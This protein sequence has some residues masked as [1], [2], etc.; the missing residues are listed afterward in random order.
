M[1]ISSISM[2]P[3]EGPGGGCLGQEDMTIRL[4]H[5]S[6]LQGID[7][8]EQTASDLMTASDMT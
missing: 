1:L 4:I 3:W 6:T 7:R 8:Y 5:P 2:D